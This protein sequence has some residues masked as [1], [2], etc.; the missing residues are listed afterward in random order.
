[1]DGCKAPKLSV[2]I[3][4]HGRIMDFSAYI[5]KL[6]KLAIWRKNNKHG[7]HELVVH[8][9][10]NRKIDPAPIL[11]TSFKFTAVITGGITFI[12]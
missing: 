8:K 11:H 7:E 3:V 1:M 6:E 4:S 2:G 10:I 12:L 9:E 5:S